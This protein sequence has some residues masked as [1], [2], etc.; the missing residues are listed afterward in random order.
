FGQGKPPIADLALLKVEATETLQFCADR[1]LHIKAG[2]AYNS[3]SRLQMIVQQAHTFG[4]GGGTAEI[5][6][7]LTARQ[8][9]L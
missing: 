9:K 5:L 2:A 3:G 7:D 4:I 6:K 1:A 8:L